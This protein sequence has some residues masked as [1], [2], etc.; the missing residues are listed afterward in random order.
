MSHFSQIIIKLRSLKLK[1]I[2]NRK[3]LKKSLIITCSIVLILFIIYFSFRNVFLKNFL[4]KKIAAFDNR[5]H[6]ELMVGSAKF[7]GFVGVKL[8]NVYLKAVD[9]DT[10]LKFSKLSVHISFWKVIFGRIEMKDFELENF[11]LTVT[12]TDS[13][14]NYS[15]LLISKKDSTIRDTNGE[16]V[17]SEVFNHLLRLVFDF[18]PSRVNISNFN[19]AFHLKEENLSYH[20]DHYNIKNRLFKTSIIVNENDSI[21]N[22]TFE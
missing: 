17:Y 15:F 19:I 18:I 9:Q 13:I 22:F 21:S 7:S 8:G 2:L 20:L 4:D 11:Y 3:V 14:N 1:E 16:T 5:Y 6:A 12:K 10:L